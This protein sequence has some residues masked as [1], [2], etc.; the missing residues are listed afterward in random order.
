M[1]DPSVDLAGK[2]VEWY[3]ADSLVYSDMNGTTTPAVNEGDAIKTW[4]SK[5]GS[6]KFYS[7]GDPAVTRFTLSKNAANGQPA[8]FKNNKNQACISSS[9]PF[10]KTVV[11]V[12]KYSGSVID[13]N[14]PQLIGRNGANLPT[15]LG[16]VSGTTNWIGFVYFA[17]PW[18][19]RLNGVIQASRPMPMNTVGI[20][21]YTDPT[22]VG[23]TD[24][25]ALGQAW[26][27]NGRTWKGW[28]FEVLILNDTLT[29]SERDDL[30]AY[31]SA[32][33][34]GNTRRRRYAGGYG[35]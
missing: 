30:N 27:V 18:V 6:A 26:Q 14:Y 8:L 7:T 5:V 24:D 2:L 21:E 28:I 16:D 33:Y 3:R 25:H 17:S 19:Y 20:C 1:Y 34:T 29:T 15:L 9:T 23:Y 13:W 4:V 35:L 32:R 10:V 22:G 12:A 11:A 31:L